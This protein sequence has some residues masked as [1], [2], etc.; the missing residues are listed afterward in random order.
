MTSVLDSHWGHLATKPLQALAL[1][2]V[3]SLVFH[4]PPGLAIGLALG[5]PALYSGV[6]KQI[7]WPGSM[8]SAI[9]WKD[10]AADTLAGS[11]GVLLFVAP[12]YWTAAALGVLLLIHR[13]ALP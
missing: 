13:W 3:A 1:W 10:L 9:G 11:I 2:A 5:L 6:R 8:T 4:F 12:W 7:L